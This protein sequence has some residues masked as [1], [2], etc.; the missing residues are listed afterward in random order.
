MCDAGQQVAI[1]TYSHPWLS[2]MNTTTIIAELKWTERVIKAICGL[3]PKYF[4]APHGDVDDRIRN[5]VEQLGYRNIIWNKDS[6]DWRV[7]VNPGP[8]DY[9]ASWVDGNVSQWVSQISSQ[10]TGII[11]LQ[12]ELT[13]AEAGES[14]IS[15]PIIKKSGWKIQ[16]IADC[17]ADPVW[18]FE[19][20]NRTNSSTPGGSNSSNPSGGPSN[21]IKSDAG[22]MAT[23]MTLATMG[24]VGMLAALTL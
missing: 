24:V 13:Q 18:Y 2:T 4:R 17:L 1:H 8:A 6:M 15:Y 11:S 16:T 23:G 7:P 21:S 9:Q 5:I 12:H 22:K 14:V 3:T 20:A 19:W 10:T